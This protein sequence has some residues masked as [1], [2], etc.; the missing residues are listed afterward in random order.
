MTTYYVTISGNDSNAGTSEGAAFASLGKATATATTSGDIIYVKSGTYTLTSSSSNVNGGRSTLSQGVRIEGYGTTPGDQAERPVIHAGSVIGIT[1]LTMG[2]S[3]NTIPCAVVNMEFDGNSGSA[4]KGVVVNSQYTA[5][6]HKCLARNCPGDGFTGTAPIV[7]FCCSAINCGNGFNAFF[8]A[9]NCVAQG[10]SSGG[11]VAVSSVAYC[12]ASGCSGIGFD[13]GGVLGFSAINCTSHG[14]GSHGFA[15]VYDIGTI[16]NCIATSNGGWGISHSA[17][18]NGLTLVN[19]ATRSNTSGAIQN[20]VVNAVNSIALGADPYTNAPGND[21]SLNSAS[22][23]GALL[24]G[25]QKTAPGD[26]PSTYLDVGCY[27]HQDSGGASS[28]GF[29][30]VGNGGLV[31]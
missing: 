4:N 24:R 23:G 25:L 21:F 9:N 8:H 27:Q 19:F 20:A 3:Y 13:F 2:A 10:C 12:R 28:G 30:L 26:T 29:S 18:N 11:F 17:A 5:N 14:N 31:Y 1:M 16:V 7:I 6:I 15:A 22:G